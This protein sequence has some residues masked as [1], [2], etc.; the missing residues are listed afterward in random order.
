MAISKRVLK[1]SDASYHVEANKHWSST[2]RSNPACIFV[3]ESSFDVS[4]AI[5]IFVDNN[6]QFAV[7]GGGHTTNP[8]WASTNSGVLISLSKLTA[9]EISDDTKSVVIGA[10]NRW[11][12]V[13]ARIGEY[14]VTVAGGRVSGVGVSGF[15]LGGG[16]SFLMHSEGFSADTVLSYE[17]VLASGEVATVTSK[18][19][20]DL[21]RA[22]KGGTGNFGIVTSFTLQTYPIGKIHAGYLFYAPDQTEEL[23][24]L[25]ETYAREG[26]EIDPKTH[27]IQVFACT[28]SQNVDMAAL[29]LFYPEP[30]TI[31]PPVIKPFLDAS[32][33]EVIQVKT[34]KDAT[35]EISAGLQDGLRYD[36]HAYSVRADA[37]LF[38]QLHDIW[39]SST[40]ELNSTIPG[41][42]STMVYQSISNSMIR[43]SN[44]KG[45]N[46]LGLEPE[47]DPLMI[48]SLLFT[49]IQ[50]EDDDKVYAVIDKLMATSTSI[51]ESQD[52]LGRYI[53]LNYAGPGQ[54][55]I[56]SYGP[57]QVHFLQ[58]VKAKYDPN[59]VFERLSRG[60]FKIPSQCPNIEDGYL[61]MQ[62]GSPDQRAC[63]Y[64]S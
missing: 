61:N 13:Y 40:M 10:G 14:N 8:G 24:S 20:E 12:D 55:P 47:D 6:C 58:K 53:Y 18:S 52:R 38:K 5:K 39:H 2:A 62:T 60:G 42:S 22:L 17:I 26:V 11:G 41:W 29:Y 37:R 27:L 21:F 1:S 64:F 50:P 49:W 19:N 3:P 54:N 25:M 56:E 46:V 48:I 43:A 34:M 28:P 51:A 44:K 35:D 30:F 15:L 7:R 4:V 31:S 57:A 63:F 32:V 59:G 16:L 45:G 36:I 33:Q 9:I 23:F